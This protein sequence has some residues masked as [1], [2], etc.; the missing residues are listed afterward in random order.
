[1]PV[2]QLR[3]PTRGRCRGTARSARAGARPGCRRSSACLPMNQSSVEK[4]GWVPQIAT[5]SRPVAARA[6]LTAAVVA[7]EP[8]LANF[9]M[10]APGTWSRN[11]SAAS[12]SQIARPGEAHASRP[13]P[14]RGCHHRL[15]AVPERHRPQTHAV[16][17]EPVAVEVLDPCTP[18]VDQ[19]RGHRL[20]VLVRRPRVGV[21]AARNDL[22]QTA[23]CNSRSI[24]QLWPPKAT[25]SGHTESLTLGSRRTLDPTSM[26]VRT[27]QHR[28]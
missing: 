21:G 23:L 12:S 2:E 17:D 8:F 16:L 10:S 7:S 19:D 22:V 6:S 26:T 27:G 14:G 13:R 24:K 11:V 20:R 3:A 18:A 28:R 9:T 5:R 15:V 1:M 25:G 4:N